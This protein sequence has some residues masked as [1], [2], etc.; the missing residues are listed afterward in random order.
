MPVDVARSYA[1]D[2][3]AARLKEGIEGSPAVL[4]GLCALGPRGAD[5]H[6]ARGALAD[7]SLEGRVEITVT[8]ADKRRELRGREER[9]HRLAIPRGDDSDRSADARGFEGAIDGW[10]HDDVMPSNEEGSAEGRAQRREALRCGR[11]RG[12]LDW[13]L[14]SSVALHARGHVVASFRD[15]HHDPRCA[16]F[17]HGERRSKGEREPRELIER[18][19]PRDGQR[20]HDR[21][22]RPRLAVGKRCH[23]APS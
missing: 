18:I 19:G 14:D 8:L 6:R 11:A 5:I 9:A 7:E 13:D 20:E 15:E 17:L 1:V 23:G 3:L 22:E 4:R 10:I 12:D 16:L 21:G 2:R